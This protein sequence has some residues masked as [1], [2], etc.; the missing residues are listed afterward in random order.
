MSDSDNRD[1]IAFIAL[2]SNM[3]APLQNIK[4][5]IALLKQSHVEILKESPYYLTKPYGYRDQPDFVNSAV[6]VKISLSVKGLFSL[7]KSIEKK[8]GREQGVKYGPRVID[9]DIIFFNRLIYQ[10]VVITIPHP[11][12]QERSFVLY[13][14]CDLDKDFV[15]PLFKKTLGT[16]KNQLVEDFGIKRIE[17]HEAS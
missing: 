7:L 6:M 14:L 3:G 16:L 9:L 5:A 17:A 12:M 11:K 15:H 10:D 8:M 13:P 4:D 2:G 1:N